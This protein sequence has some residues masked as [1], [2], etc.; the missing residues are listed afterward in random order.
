MYLFYYILGLPEICY[1]LYYGYIVYFQLFAVNIKSMTA[2]RLLRSITLACCSAA[3]TTF[4]YNYFH[5]E[6]TEVLFFYGT[7]PICNLHRNI[8]TTTTSIQN[9]ECFE[10]KL[11]IIIGWLNKAKNTLDVCMYMLNHELL[12]NAVIDAHKRG[13]NVRIILNEDNLNTTWAMGNMG[14]SKKVNKGKHNEH[15]M[16]HK[17]VII[18][19][20]KIILGSLNWTKASVRANWENSFITNNCELVNPFRQEFQK[21]WKQFN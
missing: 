3:F 2:I 14:I 6:E 13:V 17:F 1:R 15:L 19:N 16:H 12:A 11:N 10:C 4:L 9:N 5:R 20:K 8:A 7:L 21:L 18:D